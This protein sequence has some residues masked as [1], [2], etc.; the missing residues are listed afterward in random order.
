[1]VMA[2]GA[3]SAGRDADVRTGDDGSAVPGAA[4]A[5]ARRR[6]RAFCGR[7][8]RPRSGPVEAHADA[9]D[10]RPQDPARGGERGPAALPEV[11]LATQD[12]HWRKL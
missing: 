12:C 2:R 5:W 8:A 10:P 4:C 9:A 3:G 6:G 1:M 11:S 7:C